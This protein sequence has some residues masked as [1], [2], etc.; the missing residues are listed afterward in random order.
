MKARDAALK[1]GDLAKF[2]EEDKKLTDAIN[3]LLELDAAATQE[4]AADDA[5]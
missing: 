4:P 3:K 2:A 5:K 1:A